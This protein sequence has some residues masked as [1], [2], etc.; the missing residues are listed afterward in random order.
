M[1]WQHRT[2]S[3]RES[4][5]NG[6]GNGNNRTPTRNNTARDSGRADR[7]RS[8]HNRARGTGNRANRGRYRADNDTT[9]RRNNDDCNKHH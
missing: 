5:D 3:Y 4:D 1:R 8:H 7:E 6:I 2:A 9:D